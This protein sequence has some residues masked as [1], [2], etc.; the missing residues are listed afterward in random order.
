MLERALSSAALGLVLITATGTKA[1]TF[2]QFRDW[3]VT[4]SEGLTCSASVSDGGEGIYGLSLTRG[5]AAD[6]PLGLILNTSSGGP[7]SGPV[8]F[9]VDGKPAGE[10]SADAFTVSNSGALETEAAMVAETILP[11][12]RNGSE[13]TVSF[14]QGAETLTQTFS[15]SGLAASLLFLDETQRRDGTVTALAA[16]GD[17]PARDVS[18]LPDDIETPDDLPPPVRDAWEQSGSDCASF[19]SFTPEPL[20]FSAT[21]ESSRLFGLVCG[22]PGAYN[23]YYEMFL[24]SGGMVTPVPLPDMAP[25]GPIAVTGAWNVSWDDRTKTLTAFFKGRGLGDCG[26]YDRWQWSEGAGPVGGFVLL[27]SRSKPDCDGD[28]AGGPE[29]WPADWPKS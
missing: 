23:F 29:A 10:L 9:A 11:V 25:E 13:M 16:K 4:C 26:S 15:L 28:Y 20:G 24:D 7:A 14:P 17:E 21:V 12:M 3:A 8:T 22:S 27:Q 2:R 5:K 18:L 6:A 19:G 1:D